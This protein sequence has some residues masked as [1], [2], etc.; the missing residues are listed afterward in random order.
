[1]AISY[2]DGLNQ[3]FDDLVDSSLETLTDQ[4]A[5]NNFAAPPLPTPLSMTMPPVVANLSTS[6]N[7]VPDDGILDRSDI[8][9]DGKTG[10]ERCKG[11]RAGLPPS[12]LANEYS[13]RG[14]WER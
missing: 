5:D 4:K 3:N 12:H 11:S 13:G 14:G 8:G 6:V 9:T 2:E 7:L 10:Y 1:M